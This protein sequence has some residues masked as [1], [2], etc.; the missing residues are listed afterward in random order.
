MPQS[1]CKRPGWKRARDQRTRRR[2]IRNPTQSLL[3]P[4][5]PRCRRRS[6]L[7]AK[8]GRSRMPKIPRS[9]LKRKRGSQTGKTRRRRRGSCM[10]HCWQAAL[11]VHECLRLFCMPLY[12]LPPLH[13]KHPAIMLQKLRCC[14]V[15]SWTCLRLR[16]LVL[17]DPQSL[18]DAT[19]VVP[20]SAQPPVPWCPACN[21]VPRSSAS[22]EQQTLESAVWT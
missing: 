3:V 1:R 2:R 7:S 22:Q 10:S 5:Q 21:S 17:E 12:L 19:P 9:R 4:L 18:K 20:R 8:N 11:R 16:P 15:Q 13:R 6:L 14:T